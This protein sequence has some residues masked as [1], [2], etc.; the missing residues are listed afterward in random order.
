MTQQNSAW[1]RIRSRCM[2]FALVAGIA[3]PVAAQDIEPIVAIE[4]IGSQKLTSETVIFKSGLRV[5]DDLHTVDF[6][7]VLE[8]LWA[9]GDFDDIKLE[10]EDATGGKKVVIRIK[11]RPLIKEIDYRGGTEVGLTNIKDKVDRKST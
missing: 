9:S 7:A 5:G 4:V 2:P 6:S 11:E 3:S 10:L 1:N 8:K